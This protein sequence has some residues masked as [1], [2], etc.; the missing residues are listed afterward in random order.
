DELPP[1]SP[2]RAVLFVWPLFGQNYTAAIQAAKVALVFLASRNRDE[3]TRCCF[4]IPA[5]GTAMLAPYT[6]TLASLYEEDREA[7]FYRSIEEMVEK[8]LLLCSNNSLR[9]SIAR[10]GHLRCI[11]SGYDIVSR[12]KAWLDELESMFF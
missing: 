3:Y 6:K 7:V 5:I 1:S 8:A 12:A 10:N 9:E 4:E 11:R 2:L